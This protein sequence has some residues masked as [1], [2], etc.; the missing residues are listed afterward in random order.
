VDRTF[1]NVLRGPGFPRR[2]IWSRELLTV[3]SDLGNAHGGK[4]LAMSKDLLVLLFALEMED[5]D[6]VGP[7]RLHYL[8]AHPRAS[9]EADLAFL[10]GN[11]QNVIELDFVPMAC[12]Q[13]LDFHYVSGSNAI[14]LSPGANHRVHNSLHCPC[15]REARKDF[16]KNGILLQLRGIRISTGGSQTAHAAKSPQL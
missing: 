13:F 1:C 2:Q 4:G 5:Q 16:D 10:A 3:E 11:G 14:L 6:F 8:A 7:S 15:K 9:A 12:G